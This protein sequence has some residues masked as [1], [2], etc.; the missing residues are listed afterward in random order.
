MY[1]HVST[2]CRS[3]YKDYYYTFQLNCCGADDGISDYGIIFGLTA[4]MLDEGPCPIAY[5]T[6]V[7][8]NPIKS[9]GGTVTL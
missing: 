3:T 8:K 6:E 1:S 9:I 7:K 4:G 2:S 5:T